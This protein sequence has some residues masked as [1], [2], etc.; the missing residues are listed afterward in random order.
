ME[1]ELEEMLK[2]SAEEHRKN[3]TMVFDS[4]EKRYAELNRGEL[5][6]ATGAFALIVNNFLNKRDLQYNWVLSVG[7]VLFALTIIL[8]SYILR[9]S[10]NR[11]EKEIQLID[12]RYELDLEMGISIKELK[13]EKPL[14]DINMK[15]VLAMKEKSNIISNEWEK[16]SN[17]LGIGKTLNTSEGIFY[18]FGIIFVLAYFLV[19]VI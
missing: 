16:L 19:N 18:V 5:I 7:V 1:K 2:R 10:A 6:V 12:R 17:D 11:Q 14:S 8:K 15:K 13:D 4:L 9:R 3:R